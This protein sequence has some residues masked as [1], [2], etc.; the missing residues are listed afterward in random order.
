C[1][2]ASNIYSKYLA[3]KYQDNVIPIIDI[4]ISEL[5]KY[6]NIEHVGIIATNQVIQSGIYE[7]KIK[8]QYQVKTTSLAGSDLVELCENYQIDKIRIYLKTY[9]NKF[10]Q[11]KIDTLL[12]GCTHFNLIKNEINEYFDGEVRIICSGYAFPDLISK[13]YLCYSCGENII[14]LTDYNEAYVNKIKTLF[15]ELKKVKIMSLNI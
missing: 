12:L 8:N 11:D 5:S 1:N 14:Y 9:F 10:K 3:Y 4:T 13:N 6:R 7:K 15:G 2:T